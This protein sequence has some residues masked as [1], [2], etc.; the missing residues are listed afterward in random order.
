[1][2]APKKRGKKERKQLTTHFPE[3]G[4]PFSK[5]TLQDYQN[6]ILLNI[7][8]INCVK[9]SEKYLTYIHNKNK[10]QTTILI[11]LKGDAVIGLCVHR[12]NKHGRI[13]DMIQ[14]F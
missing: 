12:H 2:Q 11:S 10:I 9:L 7:L 3:T 8:N 13:M 5:W 4:T 14:I 1:M 6:I